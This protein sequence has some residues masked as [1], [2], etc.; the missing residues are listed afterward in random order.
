[1]A[2]YSEDHIGKR[3]VAQSGVEIGTVEDVRDGDMYVSVEP[4]ADDEAVAGLGWDGPVSQDVHRLPDRYVSNL[5][6]STVRLRV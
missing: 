6:D 4:D 2:D 3:V 1:M 5:T